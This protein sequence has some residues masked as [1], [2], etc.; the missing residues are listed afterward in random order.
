MLPNPAG[1]KVTYDLQK[2][3]TPLSLVASAPNCLAVNASLP[4]NSMGDLIALAKSEP[5]KLNISVVGTGGLA[6][7]AMHRLLILSHVQMEFLHYQGS[8]L[9]LLAIL[10]GEAQVTH[11]P[12]AGALPQLEAGKVKVLAITQK[13]DVPLLSS[14]PTF[15]DS[16]GL[17]GYDGGGSNAYG[18]AVP[19]GTPDAVVTKIRGDIREILGRDDVKKQLAAT[20]VFPAGDVDLAEMI[21]A[22]IPRWQQWTKETESMAAGQ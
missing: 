4:V 22:Q 13:A 7:V 15:E 9:G 14:V 3:F 6:E 1:V 12:C 5:N 11:M 17:K 8:S 18:L 19:A 10:N 20:F 16:S 21:K 2:D